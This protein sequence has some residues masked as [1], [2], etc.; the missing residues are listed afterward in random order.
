MLYSSKV[1]LDQIWYPT[2]YE[3]WLAQY[4][5]KVTYEGKYSIWQI[6][7]AGRVNGIENNVDIDVMYL[8]ENN[9]RKE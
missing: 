7:E 2:K 8:E 1:Y 6:S 4:N 9:E 3:I 5:S